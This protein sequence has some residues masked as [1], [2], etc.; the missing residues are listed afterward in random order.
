VDF[1]ATS[2]AKIPII[3]AAFGGLQGKKSLCR[4]FFGVLRAKRNKLLAGGAFY[5]IKRPEFKPGPGSPVERR[6]IWFESG[7]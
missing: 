5:S 2:N 4:R 6:S 3:G 1:C 7:H